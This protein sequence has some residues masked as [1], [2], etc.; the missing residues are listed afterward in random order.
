V[1]TGG[2]AVGELTHIAGGGFGLPAGIQAGGTGI[3]RILSLTGLQLATCPT[4]TPWPLPGC[5][6]L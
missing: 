5:P 6:P 1:T 4:A 3:V 2:L